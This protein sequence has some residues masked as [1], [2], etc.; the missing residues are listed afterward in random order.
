MIDAETVD[1]VI[2]HTIST[3]LVDMLQHNEDGSV[4]AEAIDKM[5]PQTAAM[6]AFAT[7]DMLKSK[8]AEDPICCVVKDDPRLPSFLDNFYAYF[9][10]PE[11]ESAEEQKLQ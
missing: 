4:A 3:R 7:V 9:H 5:F 8:L 2:Q 1:A 10:P 6:M 11:G